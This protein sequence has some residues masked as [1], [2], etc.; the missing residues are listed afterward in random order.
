MPKTG[1]SSIQDSL[2][3]GLEDPAYR[4]ISLGH[5]QAS[6]TVPACFLDQP[7]DFWVFRMLGFSKLEVQRMQASH[8]RRL[9]RALVRARGRRQTP[10]LSTEHC[11]V[12]PSAALDRLRA[13]LESEGFHVAGI[14]YVRPIKSW[15]ESFFQQRNKWKKIAFQP[16][17]MRPAP[18]N[19]PDYFYAE[20]LVAL[21]E[22][23]GRENLTVRTFVG[24]NLKSN[25]AVQ[26]FC[27]SV[28]I[29]LSP[30]S[31]IR[32]NDSLSADATRLLYAY[33][34]FC[35]S[36]AQDH[37]TRR[38]VLARHLESLKGPP[39]RFHSSV[40]QPIETLIES[41]NRT[42]RDDYGVDIS[43]DLKAH[44]EGDSVREAKDLFRFPGALLEWLAE[45]SDSRVIPVGEGEA[46]A[47]D[48]AVQMKRLYGR[49]LWGALWDLGQEKIRTKARWIRKGD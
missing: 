31:I 43:E 49:P 20:K 40:F 3:F 41:Q 42:L 36:S 39:L 15:L 8:L 14:V 27:E 5:T 7:Q 1:T 26:D 24:S 2:Y 37:L 10:I 47:R 38:S 16:F 21:A 28:G 19:Y 13:F 34:H 32:S 11:W 4:Y 22:T 25:C 23:F 44:D 48:V 6:L 46:A 30:D 17:Q 9:R 33:N 18:G 45:A 29:H 12:L 35:D